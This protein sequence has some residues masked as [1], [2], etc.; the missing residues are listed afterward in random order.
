MSNELVGGFRPE[1]DNPKHWS[2]E[3]QLRSKMPQQ[4]PGDVDLRPFT[5]P[6]HHQRSTSSCVAQATVKALEIKRVQQHGREA[7]IDLSRLAVYYLAREL[8][9]PPEC[10]KDEGT[11]VSHAFDVIR[12]FGVPPEA[13]WPWDPK[14]LYTPPSWRAM[15]KAYLHKITAFYKIRSTG[16]ERV[17][18]VIEC[19]RAGNPVVYGTEVGDNW[20]DY[21]AGQVLHLPAKSTGRHATVL[22]G[23]VGGVFLGENSWGTG[24]GD[25]GFYRMAPEVIAAP[26]SSD[27]WVP[28]A[29]FEGTR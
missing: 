29:G 12:R 6:R 13:D 28:Q 9:T 2:F 14:Q 10:T 4:A 18:A 11:Y 1:P 25:D 15:R 22:L 19:L 5:T 8:M 7:H 24:W 20:Q 26:V 16:Q 3:S 23:Y 27:F 21:K 17:Q